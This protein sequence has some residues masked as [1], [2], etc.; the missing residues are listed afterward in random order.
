MVKAEEPLQPR[1]SSHRPQSEAR[2]LT[3]T[4]AVATGMNESDLQDHLLSGSHVPGIIP[5]REEHSKDP[6]L[7]ELIS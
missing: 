3:L 7:L 4:R 5:G 1:E 6:C 2:S